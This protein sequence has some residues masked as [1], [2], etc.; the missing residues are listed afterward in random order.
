MFT[1][2][3]PFRDAGIDYQVGDVVDASSWTP[4][5]MEIM[6]GRYVAEVPD[7]APSRKREGK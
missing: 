7:P 5:L 4:R 6:K 2:T 1:V 3:K